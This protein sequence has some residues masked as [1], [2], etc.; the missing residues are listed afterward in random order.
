MTVKTTN[1]LGV[2]LRSYEALHNWR[3]LIMLAGSALL[4]GLAMAGGSIAVQNSGSYAVMGLMGVLAFII[5]FVG[6]NASGLMLVDQAYDHPVRG[7][8]A[9]FIGGLQA[10]LY[11]V[12][13]LI[14]LGLGFAV[15]VLLVF[16]LSLLGRIP[17]IGGFFGFMLAGPSVVLVAMAYVVLLFAVPLM[18]VAIWHGEG[19]LGSLSH[20]ADI[21][22]KKPLEVFMHFLVLWLLVF[23]AA[24][25]IFGLVFGASMVVGGMYTPGAWNG[26]S[27]DSGGHGPMGMFMNSMANY[28]VGGP[29]ISITLVLF[30]AWSVV[31]LIYVLGMIFVYRAVS[32]GVESE[33]AGLVRERL[34][35]F[36]QKMNAYKPRGGLAQPTAPAGPESQDT[37]PQDAE[38]AAV[39]PLTVL[40]GATNPEPPTQADAVRCPAC[41]VEVRLEDAFCGSC[42]HK[43][44]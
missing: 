20:A 6:M 12:G 9:S 5:A 22:L 7:F 28:G 13:A 18:V 42:G 16:L 19:L 40:E 10:A 29:G 26:A 21:V 38:A 32:E 4:A 3:A 36:K 41:G 33:A 2:L 43:L 24:A 8:G 44:R 25:L 37:V 17:G 31:G 15:V 14:L 11:A 34:S 35:K 23:P 39:P 27:Y 1:N 30:L